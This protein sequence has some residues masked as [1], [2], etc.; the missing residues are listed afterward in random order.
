MFQMH[1]VF[2]INS[3]CLSASGCF[4]G[5]LDLFQKLSAMVTVFLSAFILLVIE[6]IVLLVI[7]IVVVLMVL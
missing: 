2:L 6:V 3:A 1:P 5:L 4:L 7:K